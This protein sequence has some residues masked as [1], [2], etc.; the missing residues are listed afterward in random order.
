MVE[1]R[2]DTGKAGFRSIWRPLFGAAALAAAH[3]LFAVVLT[4]ALIGAGYGFSG[5]AVSSYDELPRLGDGPRNGFAGIWIP[6]LLEPVIVL[7]S[8]AITR[9]YAWVG[10]ALAML[11]SLVLAVYFFT[12]FELP[13]PPVGG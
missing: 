1:E 2:P 4:F 12:T 7:V 11:A 8:L 3:V 13:D 9:R 6:V 5:N 10:P